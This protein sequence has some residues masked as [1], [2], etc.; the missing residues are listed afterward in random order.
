MIAEK[1]ISLRIPAKSC[2]KK[3][4]IFPRSIQKLSSWICVMSI[5]DQKNVLLH[6]NFY[7]LRPFKHFSL[8]NP[9][10]RLL[11]DE[12]LPQSTLLVSTSRL[13]LFLDFYHPHITFSPRGFILLPGE[14]RRIHGSRSFNKASV[15][16]QIQIYS[17][18]QYLHS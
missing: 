9:G 11:S 6:R 1:Y 16:Q 8:P 14:T 18:N 4:R 15:T 2:R 3:E 5:Y 17:L 12:S 10:I 7:S 13:A